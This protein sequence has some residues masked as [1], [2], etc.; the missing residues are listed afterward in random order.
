MNE[1]QK[2]GVIKTVTILVIVVVVFY[3]WLFIRT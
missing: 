3:A 1:E 2:K